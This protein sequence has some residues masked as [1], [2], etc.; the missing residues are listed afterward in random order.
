MISESKISILQCPICKD[1]LSQEGNYLVCISCKSAF[2]VIDNIAVFLTKDDLSDFASQAWGSELQSWGFTYVSNEEPIENLQKIYEEATTEGKT[3]RLYNTGVFPSDPS[4]SD[5]LSRAVANS[6]DEI[7][8]LSN[9]KSAKRILDWPTGPGCCLHHLANQVEPETL[10]VAL[11][12]H[13]RTLAHIKPYYDK[14]G[15]SDNMLFVVADARKMPFKDNVFQAVT[16]M[17]GTVEIADADIGLRET[18]RVLEDSGWFGV[19]GDQYTEN[20][21]SMEIAERLGLGS[22]ATR[23]RFE[24]AMER[25]GFKNLQYE[26]LFEGF[27]IVSDNL[28]DEERCPLAARGDWFQ[29]V[30]ASGQKTI[31]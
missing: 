18:F 17:G 10:V 12:V 25:T 28:P 14:F 15:L 7:V 3:M 30:V 27:D 23:N 6:R 16:A 8:N 26:V 29:H 2:P 21:P 22:L 4:I 31:R 20:S 5:E 19:S 24:A 9:A 1:S 13:F 11:D